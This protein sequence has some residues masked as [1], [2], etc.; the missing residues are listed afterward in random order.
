MPERVRTAAHGDRHVEAAGAD[1]QHPGGAAERRVAV[2]AEQRSGRGPRRSPCAPGGRCRCRAWRT[3][4][5]TCARRSADSGGRR[6]CGSRSGRPVVDVGRPPA[7]G[8]TR[9]KPMR[10][11]LQ[12]RLRPVGVGQQHLVD[13]E[14][15][16]LAERPRARDQVASRSA[17]GSGSGR[18]G[19]RRLLDRLEVAALGAR[20]SRRGGGSGG[21][22]RAARARLARPARDA[23]GRDDG[24]EQVDR[25]AERVE[26][27]RRVEIDVRN[28]P[29]LLA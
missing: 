10:L 3:S 29:L 22:R 28:Q 8:T 4:R 7:P 21:C 11:E 5:R 23:A 25:D 26:E 9:G 18:I 13:A 17:C 12:P 14:A 2:G 20:C 27:G 15:D 24:R 19:S 6:C 16:L 1:G